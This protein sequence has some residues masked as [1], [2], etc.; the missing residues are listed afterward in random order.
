MVFETNTYSFK[1]TSVKTGRLVESKLKFWRTGEDVNKGSPEALR[2]TVMTLIRFSLLLVTLFSQVADS[3]LDGL[4]F[5]RLQLLPRMVHV[6]GWV[7]AV[8]GFLLFTCK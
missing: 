8:Q 1:D 4:Y 2:E 6:P 5:I 3:L 7:Q